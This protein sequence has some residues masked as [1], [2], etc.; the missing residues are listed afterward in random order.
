[1]ILDWYVVAE[2][3]E[4]EGLNIKIGTDKLSEA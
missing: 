2:S 4:F 3:N 1:M